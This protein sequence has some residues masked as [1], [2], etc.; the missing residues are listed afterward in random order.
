MKQ[1]F[2]KFMKKRHAFE[3][4]RRE[5]AAEGLTIDDLDLQFIDEGSEFILNNGCIFFW[6]NAVTDVDWAELDRIWVEMM[7]GKSAEFVAKYL[8]SES[9]SLGLLLH[10]TCD[11]CRHAYMGNSQLRCNKFNG[12]VMM[13]ED[14]CSNFEP[15]R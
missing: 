7:R 13:A 12:A 15:K 14:Y 5:L 10:I 2:I 11:K 4:F 3:E 1:K 6:K 9:D 8:N